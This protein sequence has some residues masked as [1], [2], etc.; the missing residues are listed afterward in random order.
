MSRQAFGLDLHAD[1][2]SLL[3]NAKHLDVCLRVRRRCQSKAGKN[4][5]DDRRCAIAHRSSPPTA[6]CSGTKSSKTQQCISKTTQLMTL[7]FDKNSQLFGDSRGEC[8]LE[9]ATR[10]TGR[11]T[12]PES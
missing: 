2:L 9:E 5:A 12:S 1:V 3:G 4:K 6:A 8:H 11:S 10:L 7:L